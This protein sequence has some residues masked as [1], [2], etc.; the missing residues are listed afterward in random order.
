MSYVCYQV[1]HQFLFLSNPEA[2]CPLGPGPGSKRARALDPEGPMARGSAESLFNENENEVV[3]M[4][5]YPKRK[6]KKRK[7]NDNEYV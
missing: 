5:V 4:P 3:G 6:K 7:K 2:L 1:K